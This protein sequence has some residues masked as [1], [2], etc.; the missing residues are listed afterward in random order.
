MPPHR[1]APLGSVAVFSSWPL[2]A[3]TKKLVLFSAKFPLDKS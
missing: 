2:D 1:R 3:Q